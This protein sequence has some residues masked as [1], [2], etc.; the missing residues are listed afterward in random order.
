MKLSIIIPVYQ[1]EQYVG[2]TLDTVF[3]TEARADEFEV[4]V[5]NDGTKDRSMEV[6]RQFAGRPNLTILEQENQGL[7]SARMK[8]L[9]VASGDYV[10]FVDSD[11][12]LVEDGV[13]KVL[14]L[15]EERPGADVLMFPYLNVY[16]D[17]SKNRLSYQVDEERIVTGKDVIRVLGLEVYSIVR[18]VLRRSLMDNKWLFFPVGLLHEDEYFGP[19]LLSLA[20]K[21]HVLPGHV[22]VHVHRPGSIMSTLSIRSSYDLVSIYRMLIRFMEQALTPSD[23]SWFRPYCLGRLTS[24]YKRWADSYDVPGL[25]MFALK[26]GFYVWH[27]WNK[28]FPESPF[29]KKVGRLFYY[30]M[31]GVHT[32]IL[33]RG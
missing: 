24:G 15:L 31:P 8:G 2:K 17:S 26:N 11:D 22:Y 7:S 3:A 21:V 33:G 12:Y 32:R 1:V 18:Y 5:V 9:S 20:E 29:R 27:E 28:A 4:I 23:Q 30:L 6:V 25:G 10:W 19:V 13:G 14:K 16:A